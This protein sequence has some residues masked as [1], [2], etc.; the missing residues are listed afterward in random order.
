MNPTIKYIFLSIIALISSISLLQGYKNSLRLSQDF[1][2]SPSR[3][4]L[5]GENPYEVFLSGNSDNYIILSQA[6]NYLHQLYILLSPLGYLEF[7]TAKSAWAIINILLACALGIMIFQIYKIKII[8]AIFTMLLFFCSTPFRNGLGNGQHAILMLSFLIIPFLK[9]S[10]FNNI[11]FIIQ[12]IGYSKY[13]FAPPFLIFNFFRHGIYRAC[14][15]IIPTAAG[16]FAFSYWTGTP[17]HISV[18]QPLM[19]AGTSV[20]TGTAD[21][22][23]IFELFVSDN[24]IWS[25]LSALFFATMLS[26][27]ASN[28]FNINTHLPLICITSLI[29]FKHLGYDFV[30]LLPVAA[31]A[32]YTNKL[33]VKF[34]IWISI[35]WFWFGLKALD[36]AI[37]FIDIEREPLNNTLLPINFVILITLFIV[38]LKYGNTSHHIKN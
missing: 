3:L 17:A 12:G 30:F 27:L 36:L 22:M 26:Y 4:F 28:N 31:F 6:P 20:G 23:S 1:Q 11:Q 5:L 21:F 32:F 8:W 10:R 9:T 2:W 15:G 33:H 38:I 19:V 7:D 25:G 34:F 13:S 37:S 24:M 18:I 16:I 14:L 29:T 35:A